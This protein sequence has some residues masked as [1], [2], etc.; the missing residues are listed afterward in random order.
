M[1]ENWKP[2]VNSF[3]DGPLHTERLKLPLT[4]TFVV[5]KKQNDRTIECQMTLLSLVQEK[6]LGNCQ[7]F[8]N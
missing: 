3:M 2:G 1:S 7:I 4:F 5:I 6:I 8:I